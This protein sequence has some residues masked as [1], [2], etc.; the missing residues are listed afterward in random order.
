[1]LYRVQ[2]T[3]DRIRETRTLEISKELATANLLKK[4]AAA[5][6]PK[7]SPPAKLNLLA[8]DGEGD[9]AN[10]LLFALLGAGKM[11]DKAC[12]AA[13]TSPNFK[14]QKTGCPFSHDPVVLRKHVEDNLASS[15]AYLRTH[16]GMSTEQIKALVDTLLR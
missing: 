6:M 14:C 12:W 3:K 11:E 9:D 16:L 7:A 8:E 5:A 2:A 10:S 15:L 13:T 4:S 1:V